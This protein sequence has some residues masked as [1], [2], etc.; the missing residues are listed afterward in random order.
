MSNAIL[1][2]ALAAGAGYLIYNANKKKPVGDAKPAGGGGGGGSIGSM[3]VNGNINF[4]IPEFMNVINNSTGGKV[5][6]NFPNSL[7]HLI[8][9][10]KPTI[11][12]SGK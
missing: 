2:I 10:I 8:R 7:G 4:G 1:Y 6:T 11:A 3:P 12:V 9:G 5:P